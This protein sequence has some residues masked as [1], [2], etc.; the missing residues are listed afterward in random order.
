M[1]FNQKAE[2]LCNKRGRGS[3]FQ[4]R[5]VETSMMC[6]RWSKVVIRRHDV[7]ASFASRIQTTARVEYIQVIEKIC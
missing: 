2:M 6:K 7:L 5:D 4:R 3:T 1:N